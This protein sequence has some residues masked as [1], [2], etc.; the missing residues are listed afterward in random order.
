[1]EA[2][3]GKLPSVYIANHCRCPPTHPKIIEGEPAKCLKNRE[4]GALDTKLRLKDTAHP[5]QYATDGDLLTFWLS[6]I[7]ENV[8]LDINLLY[9]RLQVK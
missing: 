9:E 6:E 3:T 5:I 2:F 7:T 1:M 4:I 8:T